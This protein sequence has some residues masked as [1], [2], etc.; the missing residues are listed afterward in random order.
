VPSRSIWQ[1]KVRAAA[2]EFAGCF[3]DKTGASYYSLQRNNHMHN[4][5]AQ[6]RDAGM[7]PEGRTLMLPPLQKKVHDFFQSR[8]DL[9]FET[10]IN[11]GF[12]QSVLMPMI[13]IDAEQTGRGTLLIVSSP[14]EAED[15]QREN[16]GGIVAET[17]ERIIDGL[18]G[19]SGDF[20]GVKRV[21]IACPQ[22]EACAGFSADI[23]FIYSRTGFSPQTLI[24]TEKLHPGLRS[25]RKLLSRPK[26]IEKKDIILLKNHKE[27]TQFP[28]EEVEDFLR[29]AGRDIYGENAG[30]LLAY[31]KIFTKNV[32][33]LN[34]SN[35]AAYLLKLAFES[36]DQARPPAPAG[37]SRY[38]QKNRSRPDMRMLFFG[39]GKNRKI[40]P[41]DISGLILGRF[42]EMDKNDIGEIRIL[43]SYSFVE[44]AENHV[45]TVIEALNGTE[46][47][48]KTLAVNYARKKEALGK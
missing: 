8:K 23:L 44:V 5:T 10:H 27:N 24:F 33:L 48:G 38:G 34:R 31:R 26:I 32:S 40:F 36:K 6:T 18:R 35:V 37:E 41:R 9:I 21:V 39:L 16:P 20:H 28:W 30:A 46:Y 47:R 14:K 4:N 15:M 43:D 3:L 42:P 12:F 2:L 13:R 22:E 17:P 45:Q 11:S 19:G 25:I 1:K 7:V 29:C